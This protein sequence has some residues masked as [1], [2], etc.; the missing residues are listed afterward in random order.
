MDKQP[1]IVGVGAANADLNGASLAP[2]HLRD[3]NPGHISLSAGGVTRNVCEN[4]ARLGADVKLL[5]CVGDDTFGAFI[6]RS[7]EDAGI[8]ASHLY[9][10]RGASSS[11]YLSILDADG[12]MLVGM[13]DMRIVQ[14]DM[15]EDYL[16]S[17]KALIQG[18]DVVT[19]S[20]H[21]LIFGMFLAVT[22]AEV[23]ALRLDRVRR[24][25]FWPAGKPHGR[26]SRRHAVQGIGP[27]CRPQRKQPRQRVAAQNNLGI[28]LYRIL[29]TD[30]RHSLL[31]P[32]QRILCPAAEALLAPRGR[33]GPRRQVVVPIFHGDS[34]QQ[35][36]S[37]G[38]PSQG[39]RFPFHPCRVVLV[40]HLQQQVFG[41][42]RAID[43]ESFLPHLHYI[44]T[45]SAQ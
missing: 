37:C 3:S 1:Y 19:H 10:A 22:K 42:D 41:A 17:K 44:C 12:D 9:A 5:S 15:P 45:T 36:R 2:I 14:Q 34:D 38:L 8:D 31:Q 11:M 39:F 18:A 30:A 35:K 6:R 23:N 27:G 43:S 24:F 21:R 32:R 26:R 13:S 7:C 29:P 16:P 25:V 40:R 4:L 33:C 20:R 28:F